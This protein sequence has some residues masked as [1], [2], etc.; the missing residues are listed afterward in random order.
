MEYIGIA[1]TAVIAIENLI[2]IILL[3]KQNGL[4]KTRARYGVGGNAA[5]VNNISNSTNNARVS[6]DTQ[7]ITAR[8][9]MTYGTMICRKCYNPVSLT[10]KK[11]AYC[12]QVLNVK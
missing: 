3:A 7:N 5:T 8:T 11:C 10:T 12:G 6:K 9:N 2:I 1:I 4:L